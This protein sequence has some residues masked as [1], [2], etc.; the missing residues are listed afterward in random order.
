VDHLGPRWTTC[1][2]QSQQ[3]LTDR[4]RICYADRA[5]SV[6]KSQICECRRGSAAE[7]NGG[8][9]VNL[10]GQNAL[11]TGATSGIGRAIALALSRAGLHVT[12]VGRDKRNL[13]GT[14]KQAPGPVQTFAA[15]L[16]TEQGIAAV[17]QAAP[18]ELH[19]LVHGAGVY[20]K[21]PIRS[22]PLSD[23]QYVQSVNLNAPLL[24]TAACLQKLKA[25]SGQIVFI[26]SSI[27]LGAGTPQLAAYAASKHG[28]RV[29]A[30]ALRQEL[31]GEGIR[32]LSVFPG[33]TD[34]PMQSQIL[35]AEGRVASSGTL[36]DPSDV[37]GM[38]IA[39]LQ[40]PKTA[41]VTDIMMRPMKRL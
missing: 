26:N 10:K 20:V 4:Y 28:L 6:F 41:E 14:A 29:A 30:D 1:S 13:E 21:G 22:L 23:L 34:T 24:L 25:G 17:A 35:A 18:P 32:I 40:V 15:D 38:V 27:G 19:V 31:S 8:V 33:R 36:I 3:T 12:L 11:V 7:V 39:A 5:R 2:A 9:P 16:A 37:A